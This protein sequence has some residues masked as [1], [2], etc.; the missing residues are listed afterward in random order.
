MTPDER[1]TELLALN[2]AQTN[3]IRMLRAQ[4]NAA[5]KLIHVALVD[6][7]LANILALQTG[8]SYIDMRTRSRD[9]LDL[10]QRIELLEKDAWTQ[11]TGVAKEFVETSIHL[12]AN[13]HY[14]EDLA[15]FI[16]QW[17]TKFKSVLG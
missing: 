4:R 12:L 9:L 5:R 15:Y 7:P 17:S 14:T 6:G 1:I 13:P 3:E 11:T 10:Y 16:E 8:E 2:T